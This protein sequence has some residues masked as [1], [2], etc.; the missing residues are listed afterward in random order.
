MSSSYHFISWIQF[1]SGNFGTLAS[2]LSSYKNPCDVELIQRLMYLVQLG[3]VFRLQKGFPSPTVSASSLIANSGTLSCTGRHFTGK[4]AVDDTW[5]H[6]CAPQFS[7]SSLFYR[8][9]C[10]CFQTERSST[11]LSQSIYT[12]GPLLSPITPL[13]DQI[14][15]HFNG[16][17]TCLAWTHSRV[18]TASTCLT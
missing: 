17:Q 1:L 8:C 14:Y 13:Q 6:I 12:K 18:V 2:W 11:W 16:H 10:G 15:F 7:L 3:L 5:W 4:V 9:T